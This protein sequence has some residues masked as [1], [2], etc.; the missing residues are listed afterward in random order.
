[1]AEPIHVTDATFEQ[2]VLKSNVPV[3]VDFWAEWCPPCHMIAPA[4]DA[5]AAEYDGQLIVAKVNAD[6]NPEAVMSYG[7]MGLP[8]LLFIQDGQL[9]DRMVG[10]A[11]RPVIKSRIERLITTSFALT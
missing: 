11:P 9:I 8:V 5:L 2:V 7:V 6:E 3:V 4:L 1:M 10:A